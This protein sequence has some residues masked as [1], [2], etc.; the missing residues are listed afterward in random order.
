MLARDGTSG[1]KGPKL[2][3]GVTALRPVRSGPRDLGRREAEQVRARMREEP[4]KVS[5]GGSSILEQNAVAASTD[6]D[7][8]KRLAEFNSFFG[9]RYSVPG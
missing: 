3:E 6:A 8:A 7:Y 1:S 4:S 9:Q 5:I 2:S